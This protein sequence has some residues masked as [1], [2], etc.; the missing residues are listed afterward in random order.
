MVWAFSDCDFFRVTPEGHPYTPTIRRVCIHGAPG[1]SL[2]ALVT[3][4][5]YR[6]SNCQR[7][8][9]PRLVS[10]AAAASALCCLG[11]TSAFI[12]TSGSTHT[13]HPIRSSDVAGLSAASC[14]T[15]SETMTF[16]IVRNQRQ[17]QQEQP[18]AGA[19]RHRWPA[20]AGKSCRA[21]QTR[22]QAHKTPTGSE[23]SKTAGGQAADDAVGD[24][25][26]E[27][28]DAS[29]LDELL[30]RCAEATKSDTARD[31]SHT[32][33]SE[34]A[35]FKTAPALLE[36][37]THPWCVL[38]VMSDWLTLLVLHQ[39]VEIIRS[40]SCCDV[41]AA[42]FPRGRWHVLCTTLSFSALSARR[43]ASVNGIRFGKR[44]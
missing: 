40:P 39:R 30:M 22:Q 29:L 15:C 5:C 41:V 33:S 11:Q 19:A 37:R 32:G 9:A 3:A 12:T 31:S 26:G 10:V 23:V 36:V 8:M 43:T 17:H 42:A 20:G 2:A 4:A 21:A 6:E 24:P 27:G 1:S 25:A 44:L 14:S 7:R 38:L 34:W 28:E 18:S 35:G 13:Y 16:R